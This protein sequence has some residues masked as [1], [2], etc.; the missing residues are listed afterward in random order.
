M[1]DT[2]IPDG[3]MLENGYVVMTDERMDI[4]CKRATEQ[5]VENL[6][7]KGLPVSMWD[8]DKQNAYLLYP[9]GRREYV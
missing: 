9:D 1:E 6:K 4:A 7:L 8:E 5:A 2:N 3:F